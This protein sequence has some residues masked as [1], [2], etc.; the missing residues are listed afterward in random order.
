MPLQNQ[1]VSSR[2]KHINIREYYVQEYLKELGEIKHVAS[3]YNFADILTKNVKVLTFERLTSTLL[4]GFEGYND[5]FQ[6][7]KHERENI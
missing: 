5:K 3:Q 2:T 7:S 1:H 6:F 4:N